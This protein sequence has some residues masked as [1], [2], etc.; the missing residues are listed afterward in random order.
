MSAVN[1]VQKILSELTPQ[2]YAVVSKKV[3]LAGVNIMNLSE[4]EALALLTRLRAAVGTVSNPIQEGIQ[5]H[6][7]FLDD[8]KA[9]K[10]SLWEE[11]RKEYYTHLSK[12]HGDNDTVKNRDKA[13]ELF[14]EMQLAGEH[15]VAATKRANN[16]AIMNI[17]SGLA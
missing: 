17:W 13:D 3:D 15:M 4:P 8:K 16:N 1:Q 5:E 9:K 11:A 7:A 12:L 2:Q 10:A 14:F 6:Q